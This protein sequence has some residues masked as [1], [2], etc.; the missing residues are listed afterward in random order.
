[1]NL[2]TQHIITTTQK[3]Y[4]HH[5]NKKEKRKQRIQEGTSLP[6]TISL[7]LKCCAESVTG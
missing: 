2:P 3:G 4:H 5:S 6:Y 1:M 7:V